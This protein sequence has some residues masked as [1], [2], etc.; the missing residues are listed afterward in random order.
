MTALLIPPLPDYLSAGVRI[1]DFFFE[2]LSG[3]FSIFSSIIVSLQSSK[4]PQQLP[5]SAKQLDLN[6]VLDSLKK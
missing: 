2:D 5:T 1:Q 4:S 6:G 3:L